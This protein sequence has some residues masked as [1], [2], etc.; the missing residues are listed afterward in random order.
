[1][2]S[3]IAEIAAMSRIAVNAVLEDVSL[4]NFNATMDGVSRR[5]GHVTVMT[6]AKMAVMNAFAPQKRPALSVHHRNS[7]AVLKISAYHS[8]SNVMATMIALMA[9]TRLA[10]L[11][12]LLWNLHR[13]MSLSGEQKLSV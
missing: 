6:I 2:A 5:C 11:H 4:T 7:I 9:V 10:V 8:D 1:M 12:Q 13:V 3:S